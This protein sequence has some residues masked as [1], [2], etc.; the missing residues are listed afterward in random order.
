MFV[1]SYG[2]GVVGGGFFGRVT[3]GKSKFVFMAGIAAVVALVLGLA[4]AAGPLAAE[5]SG[6]QPGGSGVQEGLGIQGAVTITLYGPDGST[7]G[8]WKTHNSLVQPGI[9]LLV[10][11]ISGNYEAWCP[12]YDGELPAYTA[13]IGVAVGSCSEAYSSCSA[14]NTVQSSGCESSSPPTCEGWTA[15]AG[16]ASTA[17][18]CLTAC[19]LNDVASGLF[20]YPGIGF[21]GSFVTGQFDDIPSA[22]FPSPITISPGDTLAIN[23]LFT[24]S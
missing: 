9:T 21:G 11:C 22:N 10:E 20:T 12:G 17:L 5:E 18:N 4:F 19:S 8:V 23:I 13:E 2:E 3:A 16:F 15:S 6:K 14:T 1:N 24:V 7:L